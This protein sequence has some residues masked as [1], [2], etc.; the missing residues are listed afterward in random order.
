[1][2]QDYKFLKEILITLEEHSKHLIDTNELIEKLK[3]DYSDPI[4]WDNFLGHMLIL[5][6][7][8][9]IDCN[10]P[11]LGITI[12]SRGRCSFTN[13]YF[14]LTARG[15]EFIDILKDKGIFNKIKDFSVAT[16]IEIGK[17]A[18]INIVSGTVSNH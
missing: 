5:K 15:Y 4:K 11:E 7:N 8:N 9:C 13:Q 17:A 3:V 1:M 14:R 12:G 18:L 2:K 6:D 16:A 10:D